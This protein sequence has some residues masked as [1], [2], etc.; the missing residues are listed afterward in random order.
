MVPTQSL[1][2]NKRPQ[3][4]VWRE[5]SQNEGIDSKKG[6]GGATQ[7]SQSQLYDDLRGGSKVQTHF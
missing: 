6:G 5:V 4:T 1:P 3:E 7:T 2:E